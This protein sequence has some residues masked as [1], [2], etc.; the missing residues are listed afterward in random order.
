MNRRIGSFYCFNRHHDTILNN[1]GL[2]NAQP[3]DFLGGVKAQL[4]VLPLSGAW[5]ALGHNA[6][7]GDNVRQAERRF[8]NLNVVG[9]KLIGNTA[10]ESVIFATF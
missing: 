7:D 10:Q 9:R 4:D 1:H 6:L 2:A 3:A 5:R 8:E